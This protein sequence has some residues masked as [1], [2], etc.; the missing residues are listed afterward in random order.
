M[1]FSDLVCHCRMWRVRHYVIIVCDDLSVCED[2][3]IT[4]VHSVESF[5]EI[6]QIAESSKC[7]VLSFQNKIHCVTNRSVCP[8]IRLAIRSTM[9]V[10]LRGGVALILCASHLPEA[11][12]R[13]SFFI[14]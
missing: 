3:L 8:N 5:C 6:H 12:N 1:S 2:H 4:C 9:N 13:L 7:F 11:V 14:L 10:A